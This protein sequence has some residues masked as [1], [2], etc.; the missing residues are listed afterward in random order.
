MQL[1][2]TQLAVTRLKLNGRRAYPDGT[3]LELVSSL[4]GAVDVLS[5]YSSSKTVD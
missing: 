2:Y 3:S 1:T 5:E 4:N